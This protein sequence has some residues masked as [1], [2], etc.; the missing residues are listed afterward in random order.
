MAPIQTKILQIVLLGETM[1]KWGFLLHD[2]RHWEP[3]AMRLGEGNLERK[4][5]RK[6][7]EETN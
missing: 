3:D 4:K 1:I 7:E 6:K 2:F 5:E